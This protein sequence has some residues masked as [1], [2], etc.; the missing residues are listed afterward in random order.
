MEL[1]STDICGGGH[2]ANRVLL[3]SLCKTLV[4]TS[5]NI[6]YAPLLNLI[7]DGNRGKRVLIKITFFL[8]YVLVSYLG[9]QSVAV[10]G[11]DHAYLFGSVLGFEVSA[12]CYC[13]YT[14]LIRKNNRRKGE[15][16]AFENCK[17]INGDRLQ[18]S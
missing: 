7:S 8:F 3:A 2:T 13:M 18:M 5:S 12:D 15:E 11:T 17:V 6:S 14:I 10:S 4:M 16:E 1:L 9:S